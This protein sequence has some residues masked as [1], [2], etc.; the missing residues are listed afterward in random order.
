M[1]TGLIITIIAI[2]ILIFYII[3]FQVTTFRMKL[4]S[5]IDI[6]N[7]RLNDEIEENSFQK[8]FEKPQ[9]EIGKNKWLYT[10][11]DFGKMEKG[12]VQ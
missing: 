8:P 11:D 3:V 10:A 12:R 1:N 5:K 9:I 7:H 6:K 4:K 2:G